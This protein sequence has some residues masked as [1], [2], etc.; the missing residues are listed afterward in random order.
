VELTDNITLGP[1]CSIDEGAVLGY[2]P[3]RKIADTALHLGPHGR[4]RSGSV[5]YAGSYLGK[6]LET[7]HGVVI[8]EEN[9]IGDYLY[10]WNN[11]TIDYGCVIGSYVKIHCSCYVAQYTTIEDDVF[12]APGVT[13]TN[14]LHPLCSRCM[15][16]PTIKKGARIGAGAVLLPGITVGEG[17]LV[18]AGAVVTRD[19]PPQMLAVGSPAR[20]VKSVFD[21]KC[22]SG[23][24]HAPYPE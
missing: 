11:S 21:L 20:A 7:G 3:G 14:D 16:G 1:G 12:I 6:G 23:I 19:V 4:V 18:A 9:T 17:A 8:R 2:V 10:I 24:R 15:K 22:K 13:I 5:I